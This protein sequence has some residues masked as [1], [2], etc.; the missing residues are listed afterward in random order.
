MDSQEALAKAQRAGHR[1]NEGQIKQESLERLRRIANRKFRTCFIFPIAE[2]ETVFGLALWGHGLPDDQLTDEQRVNRDR[3]EQV[4]TAILNN[5]NTQ[6]RALEA[7]LDLHDI[8]FRG[9]QIFLGG[10]GNGKQTVDR[11]RC[12]DSEGAI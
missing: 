11:W 9:Y 8:K 7:E 10:R 12:S 3:W 5:G 6:K 2:F 1:A 4:R